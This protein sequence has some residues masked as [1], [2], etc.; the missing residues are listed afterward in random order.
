MPTQCLE[1]IRVELAHPEDA[2]AIL[3]VHSAAVH[4]TAAAFYSEDIISSWARLPITS[5]RIERIRQRWIEN[6]E[7]CIVVAKQNNRIIG[8]G[9]IDKNNELQ[10]LYVHPD[11]GRRGIGGKMLA[12]LEQVAI[13]WGLL[14]LCVDA[15]IN[16]EVFYGQQGFEV[17]EYGTHQLASGQEMA[18]VK[19][20]KTL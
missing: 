11:F 5:D 9:F 4:Q 8:F 15:S 16:A 7:H 12:V 14:Y 13:P 20:R 17:I 1:P 18:C 3:E 10:G 19:M 2:A 6:P